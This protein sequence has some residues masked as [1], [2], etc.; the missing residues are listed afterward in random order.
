MAVNEQRDRL[1]DPRRDRLQEYRTRA[2]GIGWLPI[3]IGVI[4]LALIGWWLFGDLTND[5]D[6]TTRTTAPVTGSPNTGTNTPSNPT[7]TPKQPQ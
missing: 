3:V 4:V 5:S 1:Q 2:E 7:T 6:N